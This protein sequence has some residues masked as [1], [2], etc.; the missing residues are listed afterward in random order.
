[1]SEV[2]SFTKEMIHTTPNRRPLYGTHGSN[3]R[4]TV[5]KAEDEMSKTFGIPATKSNRNENGD[6]SN[7]ACVQ[8][9]LDQHTELCNISK[10]PETSK[11]SKVI[12]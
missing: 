2:L 1:M 6:V 3:S 12:A 10:L 7:T 5:D 8:D 9:G 11:R 4:I